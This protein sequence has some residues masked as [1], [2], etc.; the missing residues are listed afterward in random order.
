VFGAIRLKP[1]KGSSY[2]LV[3]YSATQLAARKETI[4][5]LETK[6]QVSNAQSPRVYVVTDCYTEVEIFT[7]L[8][9]LSSKDL[10]S[11]ETQFFLNMNAEERLDDL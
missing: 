9:G 3:V 2:E 8:R 4:I 11:K 1:L 6:I 7:L 10:I 5:E